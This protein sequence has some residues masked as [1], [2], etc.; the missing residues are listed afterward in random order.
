MTDKPT[1][2]SGD[3]VTGQLLANFNQSLSATTLEIELLGIES[4]SWDPSG[5]NS[6]RMHGSFRE[7]REL[8][9]F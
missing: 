4:V 7:E 1:Y 5:N 9:R 3:T 2:I 8:I 6:E